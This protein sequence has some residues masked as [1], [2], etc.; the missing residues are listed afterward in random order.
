MERLHQQE[1]LLSLVSCLR[2]RAP[3]A[4]HWSGVIVVMM[5][6]LHALGCAST[7][8]VVSKPLPSPVVSRQEEVLDPTLLQAVLGEREGDAYRIGAGDTLLVAVYGH[9]EL[10]IAPYAGSSLNA[11]QGSRLSGLV[12]DNDGTAQFP[13]IG[14]LQVANKTSNELRLFLEQELGKYLKEPKVTVQV[15]FTGSIRYYLLGQFTQPGVKYSDRPLRL[16]EALSLGG[17]V[18]LEKASLMTA[19]VVR[20]GKRLPV[21]FQRLLREGDLRQN[22]RLR[23][24]DVVFVP[25]NS[26]DTAFVFGGNAGSN[27]RGGA[28]PFRNGRL[29]LLQALADAGFG[30]R[31]RATGKLS[32]TRVIRSQGD[33]GQLF[34]I[35]AERMLEGEAGPFPLAPGDIVFVP[36]TGIASWNEAMAELLPTLQVVSGLLTPFVQIR[37]LSQ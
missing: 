7:P 31:E 33:R 22:I 19:Y 23:S 15:V 3:R 13:L 18:Q 11:A 30:S 24:G 29:D 25:D 10:S 6:C 20:N 4:R 32:E 1:R 14:Q 2:L 12:V 9:P 16:L 28:V 34:V 37:Y 26:G 36:Q 21:N 27:P 8:A 35:D 5:L 17:S